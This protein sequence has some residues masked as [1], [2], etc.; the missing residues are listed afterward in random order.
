MDIKAGLEHR[1]WQ[2]K[3]PF[4]KGGFSVISSSYKNPS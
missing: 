1:T 4:E 3:S 2:V